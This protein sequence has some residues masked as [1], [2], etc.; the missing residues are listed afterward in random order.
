[1]PPHS[2]PAGSMNCSSPI[3]RSLQLLQRVLVA[4]VDF[5][6]VSACRIR[7]LALCKESFFRAPSMQQPGEAIISFV[8]AR[9][10][11][12]SVLLVVLPGEFLLGGPG[13]CPHRR[14]FDRY[15]VFERVWARPRP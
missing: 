3:V 5:Y 4:V 13:L 6:G 7:T 15:S 9:L 10:G 1:M 14:I 11:I 12:D 2:Q 8:A